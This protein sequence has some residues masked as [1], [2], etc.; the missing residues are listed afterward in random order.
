VTAIQYVDDARDEA[1]AHERLGFCTSL[2]DCLGGRVLPP[3]PSK[4]TWR[5]QAFFE[6]VPEAVW[7]P[8][9]C[10]RVFILDSQR[11]LLGLKG[12]SA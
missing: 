7:L 3:S 6:D 9:G 2:P 5:L 10:R 8:D 11:R 1:E 4:P 12:A